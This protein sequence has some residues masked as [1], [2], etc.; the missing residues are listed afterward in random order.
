MSGGVSTDRDNG[1]VPRL[2]KTSSG[3]AMLKYSVNF[4]MRK[5]AL[6]S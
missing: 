6:A 3:L 5:W 4:C 1:D 2:T